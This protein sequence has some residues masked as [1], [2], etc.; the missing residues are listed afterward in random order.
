MQSVLGERLVLDADR[1]PDDEHQALLKKNCKSL[2]WRQSLGCF[3]SHR[4]EECL[5]K[6]ETNFQILS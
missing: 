1:D 5:A 6:S 4:P 2:E 3:R